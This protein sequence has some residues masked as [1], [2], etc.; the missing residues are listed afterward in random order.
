MSDT[1]ATAGAPPAKKALRTVTPGSTT[2]PNAEM[3]F[4]GWAIFLG[5]L[6]LVLPLLPFV[7]AIWLVSKAVE[8]VQRQ[9]E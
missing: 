3:D 8:F 9:V 5:L 4:I 7:A 2:H 1:P 6:V